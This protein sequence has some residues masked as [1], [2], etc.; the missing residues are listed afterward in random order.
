[1]RVYALLL[2][3]ALTT[4]YG[5]AAH[6]AVSSVATARRLD[7]APAAGI[8][9]TDRLWYGGVLDP[10]IVESPGSAAKTPVSL[11]HLLDRPSVR[12][13]ESARSPRYHAVS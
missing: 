11:R 13:I 3:L 9:G 8:R 10:I 12:C 1:M 5:Y 4:G 7:V 2:G 6:V